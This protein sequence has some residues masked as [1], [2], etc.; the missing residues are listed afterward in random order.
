[1]NKFLL[2]RLQLLK[3]AEVFPELSAVSS[4]VTL[5]KMNGV[6]VSHLPLGEQ[7]SYQEKDHV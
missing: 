7:L 4:V 3:I 1:M 2:Q 5:A 6:L